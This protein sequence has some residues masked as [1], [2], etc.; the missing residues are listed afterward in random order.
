MDFWTAT[1]FIYYFTF[2]LKMYLDDSGHSFEKGGNLDVGL[3]MISWICFLVSA[4]VI[5]KSV[6]I[7]I[8]WFAI[9]LVASNFWIVY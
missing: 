5:G 6:D 1:Y 8:Q 9:G 4:T 7:S 2:R 3:A